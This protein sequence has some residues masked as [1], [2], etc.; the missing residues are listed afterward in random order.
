M[1][2]SQAQADRIAAEYDAYRKSTFEP[3]EKQIVSEATAYDTPERRAAAA[4]AARA[5][6]DIGFSRQQ[7]ANAARLAANGI[8]PGSARS[9]AAMGGAG[10]EAAKAGAGA[11]YLARKGIEDTGTA[12]KLNAASLGRNLPAAQ[13]ASANTAINAGN[14]ATNNATVPTAL[15]Q[16]AANAMNTPYQ[17]AINA[18]VQSGNLYGSN[19]A[20]T[21]RV[22]DSNSAAWGAL[23]STLGSWLGS[24]SGTD[25]IN[26]I[27]DWLSDENVKTDVAPVSE[28]AALEA[29]NATPVK[30]WRYDPAKLAAQGIQPDDGSMHVGPMAQDVNA[31]MGEQAA[32]GGKRIDP[33]TMAGVTMR[34]LQAVDKKVER[35]AKQVTS[36]ASMVKSGRME[37]RAA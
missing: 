11:S 10:V 34:G 26:S 32:P 8:N 5:D 17:S 18:A 37:A 25:T 29:V 20:I 15:N 9:I 1:L 28:D 7:A 12:M 35:L 16:T 4:E 19:A 2:A 3:L 13:N 21:S 31:T 33:I 23:G 6:V 30:Q 36:I 14:S 22:N 24:K 27:S